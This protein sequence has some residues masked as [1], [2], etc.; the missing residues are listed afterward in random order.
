LLTTLDVCQCNEIS[1]TTICRVAIKFYSQSFSL[2]RVGQLHASCSPCGFVY[3]QICGHVF[4]RQGRIYSGESIVE[5][6]AFLLS[7]SSILPAVK[8]ARN[9]AFVIDVPVIREALARDEIAP[10]TLVW[11]GAPPAPEGG[12]DGLEL[13]QE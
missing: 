6:I 13:L 7:R 1:I 5:I 12:H 8:L 4:N 11:Q 10:R 2:C 3:R 9:I